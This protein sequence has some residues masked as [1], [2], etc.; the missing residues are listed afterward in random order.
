MGYDEMEMDPD[1]AIRQLVKY[2]KSIGYFTIKGQEGLMFISPSM[3]NKKLDK[4]DLNELGK[5]SHSKNKVTQYDIPLEAYTIDMTTKAALIFKD[6]E[7]QFEK[8]ADGT[9]ETETLENLHYVLSE[10]SD[11]FLDR[12]SIE[13]NTEVN[14]EDDIKPFYDNPEVTFR[15]LDNLDVYFTVRCSGYRCSRGMLA[16]EKDKSLKHCLDKEDSDYMYFHCTS[17][18]KNNNSKVAIKLLDYF[19]RNFLIPTHHS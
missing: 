13:Y 7:K 2:Y 3:I 18:A 9:L 15:L 6:A 14:T 5:I 10:C 16:N 8:Y 19:S 17:Y 12:F 4:I 1:K 11:D